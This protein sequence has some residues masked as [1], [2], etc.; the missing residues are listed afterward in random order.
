[1]FEQPQRK[2]AS[3]QGAGAAETDSR[4]AAEA[5]CRRKG[6][7]H[8]AKGTADHEVVQGYVCCEWQALGHCTLSTSTHDCC[9]DVVRNRGKRWVAVNGTVAVPLS[10]LCLWLGQACILSTLRFRGSN[11]Y[12]LSVDRSVMQAEA[13][14]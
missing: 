11:N 13:E 1:M 4:L 2:G 9:D 3:W 12:Q 10:A 8:I 6:R 14:G 7:K 5:Q